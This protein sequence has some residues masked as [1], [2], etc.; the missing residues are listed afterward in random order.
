MPPCA[1]FSARQPLSASRVLFVFFGSRQRSHRPHRLIAARLS[2]S[3]CSAAD[4]ACSARFLSPGSS[5]KPA[6]SL[7]DI[8]QISPP[9]TP[10]ATISPSSHWKSLRLIAAAPCLPGYMRPSTLS[11]KAFQSAKVAACSL[12]N[13]LTS[14]RKTWAEGTGFAQYGGSKNPLLS[15]SEMSRIGDPQ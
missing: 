9:V 5:L 14:S 13:A 2:D 8:G 12:T 3:A 7:E 15:L 6:A 4:F 1:F 10:H 11:S